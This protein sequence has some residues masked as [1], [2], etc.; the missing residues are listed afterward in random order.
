MERPILK[1]SDRTILELDPLSF[2]IKKSAD[3]RL[4]RIPKKIMGMSSFIR[5]F[6]R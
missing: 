6:E 1:K 2:I 3:P 4:A 5:K